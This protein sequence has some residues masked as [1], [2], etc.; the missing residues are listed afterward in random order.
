MCACQAKSPRRRRR[1]TRG[2]SPTTTPSTYSRVS[3]MSKCATPAT[4]SESAASASASSL[5]GPGPPRAGAGP[6]TRVCGP[7]GSGTTP[8]IAE[9]KRSVSTAAPAVDGDASSFVGAELDGTAGAGTGLCFHSFRRFRKGEFNAGGSVSAR[10]LASSV[11]RPR[12]AIARIYHS[13]LA[14]YSQATVLGGVLRCRERQADGFSG[15]S[16]VRGRVRRHGG[17]VLGLD[18]GT[19]AL[20]GQLLKGS[21][22]ETARKDVAVLPATDGREG[23]TQGVSE[24]F[25]GETRTMPPRANELAGISGRPGADAG[26]GGIGGVELHSEVHLGRAMSNACAS[27]KMLETPCGEP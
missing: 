6:S 19:A 7:R 22:G 5:T 21:P 16:A 13:G 18:E 3:V 9:A 26:V 23:H 14:C 25:L 15:V 1:A 10:S 11:D 24:A 8:T 2:S 4:R 27:Q 20:G 17:A 12:R